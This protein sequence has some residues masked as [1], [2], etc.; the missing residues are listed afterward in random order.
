MPK[1]EED[2]D[3]PT[4]LGSHGGIRRILLTEIVE[5]AAVDLDSER[6]LSSRFAI[7]K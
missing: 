5:D 6:F 3:D 4:L 7:E 2:V 1:L